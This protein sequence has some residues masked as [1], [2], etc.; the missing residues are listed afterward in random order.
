MKETILKILKEGEKTTTE[1]ASII[2]RN[3]Y[4]TLHILEELEKEKKIKKIEIGRFTFWR[5]YNAN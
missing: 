4:D 5:L 1:I 2:R 3:H